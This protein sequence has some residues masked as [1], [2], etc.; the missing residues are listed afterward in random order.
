MRLLGG[1]AAAVAA[2]ALAGCPNPNDIGVQTYGYVAVKTV[3]ANTGQPVAN[4]L[5]NAGSTYTC[6]TGSDGSCPQPL[7][8]PVGKW[9]LVA[10]A[11]GLHG[12]ADVTI[13]ENTT[14]SVTIQLSP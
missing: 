7:K 9:P 14:A 2:L 10:S 4:V 1:F 8:L 11:P 3:D 13:A 5:V 6:T 12:S